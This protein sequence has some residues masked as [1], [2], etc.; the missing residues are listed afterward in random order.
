[1]WVWVWVCVEEKEEVC[2]V[3]E[4]TMVRA[5]V[6]SPRELENRVC[7]LQAFNLHCSVCELEPK[8]LVA[9]KQG[10]WTLKRKPGFFFF[11]LVCLL[12]LFFFF[13]RHFLPSAAMVDSK[14]G[15]Q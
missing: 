13:P 14:G 2:V 3:L 1:M 8:A 11:F 9:Q 6:P 10:L 12:V 5:A 7:G 4:E 15:S